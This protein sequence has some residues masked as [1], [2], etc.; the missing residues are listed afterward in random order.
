MTHFVGHNGSTVS[1]SGTGSCTERINIKQGSDYDLT[2]E[3]NY[4]MQEW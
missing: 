2:R 3:A 4:Y 1:H